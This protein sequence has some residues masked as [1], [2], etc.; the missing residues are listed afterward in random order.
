VAAG[1]DHFLTNVTKVNIP[2]INK[3]TPKMILPYFPFS[4]ILSS[5]FEIKKNIPVPLRR[6]NITI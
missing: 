1:F 2:E 4:K 5:F 6:T 3:M